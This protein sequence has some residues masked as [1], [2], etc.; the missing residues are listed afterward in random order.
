MSAKREIKRVIVKERTKGG[1]RVSARQGY[2]KIVSRRHFTKGRQR[3]NE[4]KKAT[5]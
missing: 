4:E 5:K 2:R 3:G 1:Q